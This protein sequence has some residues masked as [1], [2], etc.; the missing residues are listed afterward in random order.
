MIEKKE[1][2]LLNLETEQEMLDTYV[3]EGKFPTGVIGIVL[4]SE[5]GVR[6]YNLLLDTVRYKI[7]KMEEDIDQLTN[8]I[9]EDV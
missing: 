3:L 6:D 2:L 5:L 9:K 8:W 4:E 1:R 7:K